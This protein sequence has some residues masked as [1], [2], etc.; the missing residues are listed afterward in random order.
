M[1]AEEVM[2]FDDI[3]PTEIPVKI[4]DQQYTLKEATG[5]IQ[6]KYQNAASACTRLDS[7]GKFRGVEGIGDLEPL[8]V[9][10][11][12]FN[13]D[14]KNVPIE[15]IK[16]WRGSIQKKL[17][18]KAKQ[19]S[20]MEDIATT[21]KEITEKIAELQERRQELDEEEQEAKNAP[22]STTDGTG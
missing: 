12:L 15:T 4:G 13:G 6:V 3:T 7:R 16:G 20:G 10:L 21:R 11:C 8:L 22:P 17:F 18:D 1:N 5:E 2:I 19:I 9:S 14:G